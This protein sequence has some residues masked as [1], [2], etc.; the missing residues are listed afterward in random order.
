MRLIKH[1]FSTNDSQVVLCFVVRLATCLIAT[2]TSAHVFLVTPLYH[3]R[4]R[5]VAVVFAKHPS[6]CLAPWS[7]HSCCI[8]LARIFCNTGHTSFDTNYLPRFSQPFVSTKHLRKFEARVG[9]LKLVWLKSRRRKGTRGNGGA[10]CLGWK[11]CERICGATQ[12]MSQKDFE[13]LFW[14][15]SNT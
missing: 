9:D 10:M 8:P 5:Y 14:I 4:S 6:I 13:A 12:S 2:A 11:H 1:A 15:T 3:H 7:L